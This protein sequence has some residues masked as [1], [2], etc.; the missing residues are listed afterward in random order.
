M[1]RSRSA[2]RGLSPYVR[3]TGPSHPDFRLL[4]S[5]DPSGSRYDFDLTTG[6]SE[7]GMKA[8]TYATDIRTEDGAEHIWVETPEGGSGWRLVEFRPVSEGAQVSLL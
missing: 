1:R 7:T 8:C 5:F 2:T 6:H 3:G 4:D